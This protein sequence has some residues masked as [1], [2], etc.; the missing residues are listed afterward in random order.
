VPI[1]LKNQPW[2]RAE[3]AV[4][5]V[6]IEW[7][8]WQRRLPPWDDLTVGRRVILVAGGGPSTGMLTYQVEV[9]AVV[10]VA[11]TSHPDAWRQLRSGLGKALTPELL[12]R[13]GFLNHEYTTNKPASGWLLGWTYRLIGEVMLPRPADLRMGRNGWGLIDSLNLADDR[14]TPADRDDSTSGTVLSDQGQISDPLLRQRVEFYAMDAARAWLEKSGHPPDDIYDTSA[15]HPYDYEIRPAAGPAV[16][17]EVKGSLRALGAVHV[18]RGEVEQARTS[19]I[20]TILAIV[21]DIELFADD[22]DELQPFGGKLSV[23]DP[24]NP[25]DGDLTVIQYRYNTSTLAALQDLDLS[26]F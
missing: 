14:P 1:I 11:Y 17:V 19:G 9:T 21:H 2:N 22:L 26:D 8:M 16:R 7:N 23:I 12:D 25:A 3:G 5:D 10:K 24:W 20:R 18:T 15:K 4:P 6:E 13:D